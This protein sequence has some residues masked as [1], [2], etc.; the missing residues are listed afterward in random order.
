M[1]STGLIVQLLKDH[2][3]WVAIVVWMVWQTALRE[4]RM[5]KTLDAQHAQLVKMTERTSTIIAENTAGFH[6][7][8]RAIE[9]SECVKPLP[10]NGNNSG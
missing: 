2:G 9:S 6:R 8:A 3:P 5:A 4:K 1:D 7:V 10:G